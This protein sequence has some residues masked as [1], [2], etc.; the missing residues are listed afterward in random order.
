LKRVDAR[1]LAAIDAE[2][3]LDLQWMGSIQYAQVLRDR[4]PEL[5][6]LATP[7]DVKSEGIARAASTAAR[8]WVR[9]AARRALPRVSRLERRA[10]E[11][12]DRVF[13]F[14]RQDIASLR[15]LGVAT[16]AVTSPP[17][18]RLPERA[19]QPDASSRIALFTA[20]F[21]REEND[22]AA[23]WFLTEI[24]P[25]VSSEPGLKVR[26]AG[27]RPSAWLRSQ[28]GDRIEVTG[29][30]PDLLDAYQGVGL[31]I[32]PLR[33][34]AGLKFKV[35]QAVVMGYPVVGTTVALEGMDELAQRKVADPVDTGPAFAEALVDTLRQLPQRIAAAAELAL[36]LR[37]PLD[38]SCQMADQVR[39]YKD[40]LTQH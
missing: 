14:K 31:V 11:L 16:P 32:A 8:P 39:Q 20:A 21:W 27:S 26:F 24:W 17:L 2:D 5:P 13:V 37:E 33:R 22:E 9:L 40:L 29:Y 6:I 19:P 34:G 35:A 15:G 1:A 10:L 4:R 12:C 18:V 30:L 7:H 3:I 28:A 38:F 25:L 36:A 23:R